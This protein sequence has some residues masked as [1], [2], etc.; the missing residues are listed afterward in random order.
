MEFKGLF[1]IVRFLSLRVNCEW[2]WRT[3]QFGFHHL[4]PPNVK[5]KAVSFTVTG[6]KHGWRDYCPQRPL[7]RLKTLVMTIRDLLF[8]RKMQHAVCYSPNLTKGTVVV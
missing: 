8:G 1:G 2:R 4:F 6:S 5:L 7:E 3:P